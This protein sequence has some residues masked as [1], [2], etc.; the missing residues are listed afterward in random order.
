MSEVGVE[1][2][3]LLSGS[4]ESDEIAGEYSGGNEVISRSFSFFDVP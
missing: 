2:S 4:V 1:L 3:G